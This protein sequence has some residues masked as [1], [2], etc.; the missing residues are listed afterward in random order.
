MSAPILMMLE[1][2]VLAP[3]RLLAVFAVACTSFMLDFV[4]IALCTEGAIRLVNGSTPAEGRVEVCLNGVWGT[5][6]DDYFSNTDAKVVCR[7]L[8]FV[9]GEYQCYPIIINIK[10]I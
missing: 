3:V 8:H 10:L 9:D 5:V 4:P 6:T 7:Q 2:H 1:L